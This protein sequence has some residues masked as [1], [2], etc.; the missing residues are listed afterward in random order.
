MR[1]S[2]IPK[3]RYKSIEGPALQIKAIHK[4]LKKR[5][6][7]MGTAYLLLLLRSENCNCM[8][9][10]RNHL[11]SCETCGDENIGET[12]RSLYVRVKEHLARSRNSEP[13]SPL[14]THREQE[15]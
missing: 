8:R 4:D 15:T 2:R 3:M 10:R 14:G 7:R 1:F 13:R 11:I 9:C 5:L 6:R 12:G